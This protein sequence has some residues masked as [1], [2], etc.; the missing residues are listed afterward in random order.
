MYRLVV[1]KEP[2]HTLLRCGADSALREAE[3][4][5][6]KSW[7]F[8]QLV[9]KL[10]FDKTE[11]SRSISAVP[12]MLGRIWLTKMKVNGDSRQEV[13]RSKCMGGYAFL[14]VPKAPDA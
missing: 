3:E 2:K 6:C 12:L 5:G 9:G 1:Q 4:R 13:S 11:E 8:A 10:W 14:T 7:Q